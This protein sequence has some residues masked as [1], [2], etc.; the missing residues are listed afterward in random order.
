METMPDNDPMEK[1]PHTPLAGLDPADLLRQGVAEDTMMDAATRPFQPPTLEELGANF[2]QFEILELIG[3]GGMGAVY[4]VRQNDLD[5]IVALKILPPVIGE[6]A[7]FAERFTRE[8]KALAKLNHPGIVTL[9]EFGQQGGHYFILM[10]FVDGVNL[11]QLMAAQRIS[12][13]EALA[14]VPQICD[15]LQFAHDQGIVHRDIKPENILL[16]RLGR[17]KVAD[18]GI[19][20]VVA[21]VCEDPIRSGDTLVPIHETIAGKIIGTPQYM[22]P[23]Q[24]SHPSEV[25]HRADIYALGVVFY[26]MLTGELPGKDLQTPMRKVQIDVR[27]DEIVLKAMEKNPEL[28]F[29]QASVMKTRVEDLETS[30]VEP[31]PESITAKTVPRISRTAVVGVC[32]A[33]FFVLATILW[34]FSSS[35]VTEDPPITRGIYWLGI[36]LGLLILLPGVTSVFGTT[37]LGW[38]AVAQIRRSAGKLYGMWLAV[39]DGLLFPLLLLAGLIA[40]FWRWVFYDLIR[41]SIIAG[42]PQLSTLERLVVSNT[43]TFTVLTTLITSLIVSFFIIRRVWRAVK[44]YGRGNSVGTEGAI[45]SPPTG[46]QALGANG[47]KGKLA[48]PIKNTRSTGTMLAIGCGVFAVLGVISVILLSV[49]FYW[50]FESAKKAG[51]G[52]INQME[53]KLSENRAVLDQ[54]SIPAIGPVLEALEKKDEAAAV[55][56]FLEANWTVRPLFATDSVL[57]LTESR[58]AALSADERASRS[59]RMKS[60]IDNL[61]QLGTAVAKSGDLAAENG[62]V[63]QAQA[64]FSALKRFGR[65]MDDP[66]G[67]LVVR[68][69]GQSIEKEANRKLTNLEE[70]EKVGS[71]A[72]KVPK[73]PV[74]IRLI[75]NGDPFLMGEQ[76]S[77]ESLMKKLESLKQQ[78][79]DLA[80]AVKADERTKYVKVTEMLDRLGKLGITQISFATGARKDDP[81]SEPPK[82]RRLEWQDQV[83][84]CTGEAW[85]PSGEADRSNDWMPPIGGV[86]ISRTKAAKENPRFLCLWFSHPLFDRQSVTEISLLDADGKNP[87]EL[88]SGEQSTGAI[89]AAPENANT[90]WITATLCAGKKGRI[91]PKATVMLRY[92]GG[93]WQFCAE[94]APDFRGTQFLA[95]GVMLSDPGQKSDGNAFIQITRGGSAGEQFDFVAI[96]RDGRRLERNGHGESSSGKVVSERFSFDTPLAQVKSFEC[97]KRPIHQITWPVVLKDNPNTSGKM[98]IDFDRAGDSMQNILYNF[99]RKYDVRIAFENLDFDTKKDTIKLGQRIATLEEKQRSGKLTTRETELLKDAQR[100]RK[101]EKLGDETLID[102]GA[103][104]EGIIKADSVEDFLNQLTKDT[105]YDWTST[106]GGGTWVVLPRVGTRLNYPVSLDTENFTV[107]EAV[108][109]VIEQRP[110]GSEIS[111]GQVVTRPLAPGTDSDPWLHMK[112]KPEKL[113]G[114]PAWRALCMIGA[115]ARPDSVWELA[116][117]K[118]HRMLSLSPGTSMEMEVVSE[119]QAWLLTVDR[120]EYPK[121]HELASAFFQ[122]AISSEKWDEALKDVRKPLGDTKFRK[123]KS[124]VLYEKLPHVP[125]GH[126]LLMEFETEFAALK[127]T[128]ETVTFSQES[129]GSWKAAGYLIRPNP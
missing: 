110:A 108:K 87:L 57:G 43:T 113:R 9:H 100:L 38:I 79:P 41:A 53:E 104:Y 124:A 89:P 59:A 8:A 106:D 70:K 39:F 29:Q 97:R 69:L 81:Q 62:D 7:G 111:I 20:K 45:T 49:I 44:N 54:E 61:R 17:V 68:L 85:L 72:E 22:A 99:R 18:F 65:A 82:L 74:T 118:E 63:P 26:Q 1:P 46:P 36:V 37:I 71:P 86:D 55:A 101:E 102:V 83:K 42:E 60:E 125:D 16:D 21:T 23:E 28:R 90:G 11:A 66:G 12:A 3:Q 98:K 105:P 127:S 34:F 47:V 78:N 4:K 119:T 77:E 103:R 15:A 129:D 52:L 120:G 64:C 56:R 91:P 117:Y 95:D 6:Q 114:I 107:E 122:K 27:L 50:R 126:Y 33:A 92:S 5:R 96:T 75:E 73:S 80:V 115:G 35:S 25:D 13:R 31:V 51:G 40:W 32:W 121:S 84:A 10:E 24:I 2:P 76:V 30:V 93:A 123:L 112:C 116:G 67:L 48:P 88:S 58:F 109:K 14:I 94:I 19:A 128:I